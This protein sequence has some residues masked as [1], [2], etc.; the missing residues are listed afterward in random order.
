MSECMRIHPLTQKSII[1]IRK[2][3][4]QITDF[5]GLFANNFVENFMQHS[6]RM[7]CGGNR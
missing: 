5:E 2:F 6:F 7:S 3:Q 4:S 1:K